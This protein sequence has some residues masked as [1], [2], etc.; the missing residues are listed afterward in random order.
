MTLRGDEKQV[1]FLDWVQV[2]ETVMV[3]IEHR[4]RGWTIDQSKVRLTQCR[5]GEVK[6][7]WLLV[8]L[9]VEDNEKSFSWC[10]VGSSR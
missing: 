3:W 4:E 10:L 9:A 2:A 8:E 1:Q 7:L 6:R 5:P